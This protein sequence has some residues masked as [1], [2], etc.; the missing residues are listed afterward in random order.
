MARRDLVA[1]LEQRVIAAS[2]EL[3]A[4]REDL[5]RLVEV[6]VS[7]AVGEA[8]VAPLLLT[9]GQAA[10]ALGLGESTVHGLIRSGELGSRKIG[11]R[12][13]PVAELDAFVARLPF[14][15]VGC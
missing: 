2:R 7:P 13:V 6:A 11:A 12:R 10:A 5:A 9:V 15:A 14:C 1:R 8:P 3:E 4:I